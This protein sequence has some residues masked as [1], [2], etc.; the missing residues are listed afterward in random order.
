MNR[1]LKPVFEVLLRGIEDAEIQYW[2][3][4]GIAIAA[5]AGKFIRKNKDVDIFVKESAFENV[6]P[7]LHGLCDRNSFKLI[8]RTRRLRPKLEVEID[9]RE[10]L[11]VVPVYLQDDGVEFRFP[12]GLKEKHPSQI[13]ERVERDISG[14]RFFTPPNDCIRNLFRNYL[15]SRSD[16][17]NKSAV[18]IDAKAILPPDEYDQLYP[19][20]R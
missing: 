16:K 13:L 5:V 20:H 11:S 4:G 1:H 17:Q 7:V 9:E 8:R 15:A 19:A 14:Y 2:V 10:R 3:Y 12:R 6:R 18:R